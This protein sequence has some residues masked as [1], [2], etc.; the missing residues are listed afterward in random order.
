MVKHYPTDDFALFNN[1]RIKLIEEGRVSLR[2][3]SHPAQLQFFIS[4]LLNGLVYHAGAASYFN[5][6]CGINIISRV[7]HQKYQ[8]VDI[9]PPL[10]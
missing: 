2:D 5:S 1:N 3:K 6:I 9:P 8:L 10:V 7:N 4:V